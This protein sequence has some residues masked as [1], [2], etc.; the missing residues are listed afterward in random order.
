LNKRVSHKKKL[1]SFGVAMI[2]GVW[3]EVL[4]VEHWMETQLAQSGKTVLLMPQPILESKFWFIFNRRALCME[5]VMNFCIGT[6][7][8]GCS[9]F[10]SGAL[11]E[12][13]TGTNRGNSAANATTNL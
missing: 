9:R 7:R 5:S 3:E 4:A 8:V 1:M 10:G 12:D 6:K 13:T 2:R 11:V